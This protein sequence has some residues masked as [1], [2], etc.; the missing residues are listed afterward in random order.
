[1]KVFYLVE[2]ARLNFLQTTGRLFLRNKIF[3]EE[4]FRIIYK[5]ST[6][7]W[8]YRKNLPNCLLPRNAE[9]R[10]IAHERMQ[11]R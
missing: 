9:I 8:N 5:S 10:C 4:L 2:S 3:C 6:R 11:I 7:K 1:M